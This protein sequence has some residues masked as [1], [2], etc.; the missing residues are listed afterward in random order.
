MISVSTRFL[1]QPRE[2]GKTVFCFL[3][4]VFCVGVFEFIKAMNK[5]PKQSLGKNLPFPSRSLGTSL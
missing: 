2:M 4:S 5:V 1:G 3:F